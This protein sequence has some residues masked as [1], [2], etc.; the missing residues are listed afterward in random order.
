MIK[1]STI[2]EFLSSGQHEC[3]NPG[4]GDFIIICVFSFYQRLYLSIY[5]SFV[6]SKIKLN[7]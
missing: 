4:N 1:C 7:G 3:S 2:V 6:F 5:I